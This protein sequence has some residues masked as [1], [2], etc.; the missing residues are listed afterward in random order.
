M[1]DPI[2]PSTSTSDPNSNSTPTPTILLHPRREP[3]E[4]GLLPIQ[5]LIFTDPVQALTQ[6]KEKLSS[7]FA[8]RVGSAALADALQ[9]SSDHAR[10]ILD[11]LSSVLHSE[12]DPLVTARP[13]DVDS[14][15]ADLRDL[16]LFLY[17]QSYKRLLPRSHKDSAAVAD[18]WPSTSAFDGYLSALSPLQLVRSNTRRFMPSQA[19]EEAH[20]LSYLQKHLANILSL[21]S[22]HVEGEGKESMVLTIEGFE[23]LG[24]LIHFGDKGSEGVP[25]SQAAPFFAN[26][27]P[28]MPAVPVLASQ[29]HDWLLEIIAASLEHVSEKNSAK[30]SGSPSSSDQD[31]AMSDASPSSAKASQSARSSFFIEGVSKSSYVKQASDLKNSS[32]KAVRVEH[33]E[34]VHVILASKRVCIVNCRECIFF[35]GVNQRP[36]IV[37]DNHKLQVAPYN[38]FYS[39]LEEH[40]TEVGIDATINRWHEPLALGVIDPHDSLSHPAG[41]ADAQTESA[42]CLDPD[43]FTNFL[44]PNWFEGEPTKSTRNNP[45]PLPD[46][47][48]TS[49]QRNQ[50]NLGEIQQ[51]LREA[52][53]EENRKRELSCALHVYFKDWLYASGNIRQL[54]CLLG[55]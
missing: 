5:K 39:Q 19:D 3:F 43:Q 53:L 22:E 1:T 20:Q 9:I 29:V 21:L 34:R 41:V 12:S 26:S 24:F 51:I 17:I 18:V 6:L 11:T 35:L 48:F 52:P 23:H 36:L 7:S 37:G 33:C 49:Q 47:Y 8:L 54:Y 42:A 4:H 25:L 15:G 55:D 31:I 2:E 27:D 10:L 38:T 45:F 40:M 28:D 13:E 16:V 44:I 46:P 50:K 32:V 14:I 30:E